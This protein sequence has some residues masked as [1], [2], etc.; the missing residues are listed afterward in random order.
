MITH[1]DFILRTWEASHKGIPAGAQPVEDI[2]SVRVKPGR[3]RDFLT[4]FRNFDKPVYEK[5]VTD[6]VIYAYELDSEAVHTLE[7]G[8]IWVIVSMPSL[9]AKDKVNAAFDA[10]EK[11]LP[12]GQRDIMNKEYE[13][14][15]VPGSHRDSLSTSVVFRVK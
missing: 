8:L 12:E 13:G 6:G 15:T 14:V 10:A 9:G 4:M 5:L 11:A 1:H 2:D 7:P 3:G